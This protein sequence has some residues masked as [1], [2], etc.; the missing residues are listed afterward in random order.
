MSAQSVTTPEE[1][2]VGV[3]LREENDCKGA[4]VAARIR[5]PYL[6]V[7]EQQLP[8]YR[9]QDGRFLADDLWQKDLVMHLEYIHHLMLASPCLGRQAPPDAKLVEVKGSAF[10]L[11][12]LPQQRG[13]LQ[14]LTLMP[15]IV[16]R[17]S[18]A[19]RRAGIVHS[20]IVGWPIPMGWIVA[21]LALLLRK[22]LVIVVESAPWRL[23][24]GFAAGWKRRARALLQEYLGRW[25][26]HR[27]DLVICTQDE[28]RESLVGPKHPRAFVIP[29]SW[30]DE[31]DILSEEGAVGSWEKKLSHSD[32]RLN[33]L[34][35]GRL[36][37]EKGLLVLLEAIRHLGRESVPISLG[38]LGDGSLK[39]ECGL[40]ASE[41]TH[42]TVVKLLGTV[43]YGAPLFELI[44]RYDAVVVPSISDEQPR[45]VFDAFSQAVPIIASDTPGLR[46]CVRNGETGLLVKPN[47]VSALVGT[48]K[49]AVANPGRLR[50]CGL[51]G[52]LDARSM[53]HQEMHRR[54]AELLSAVVAR[55]EV[56][57][58]PDNG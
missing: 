1:P 56:A 8:I 6:I 13:F 16:Y 25:V 7:V 47:D 26:L 12:E 19:V 40:A 3:S 24:Q 41:L 28:Y 34:F 5:G 35:V 53:T 51:R 20:G 23:P 58:A 39:Q 33:I 27:A 14:A 50:E 30:I 18:K 36:T 11:I 48:L 52:L 43:P 10:E 45:I 49:F 54:R 31:K 46:S 21:P 44:R 9:G 57:A 32:G 42:S 38:I 2:L 55:R 4:P 22:P 37:A 15:V 17:L 29:A